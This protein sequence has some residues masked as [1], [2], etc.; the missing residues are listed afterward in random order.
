MP[1][2]GYARIAS[3]QQTQHDKSLDEQQRRINSRAMTEGWMIDE[4]IVECGVSGGQRLH[5][6]PRGSELLAKLQSGDV[7]I[8]AQLD[9]MFRSALDAVETVDEFKDRGIR[10]LVLD[11]AE[12]T[13]DN[14]I[15]ISILAAVAAFEHE[16]EQRANPP[17]PAD[18]KDRGF[19]QL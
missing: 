14:T 12:I 8:C 16:F 13:G 4:M 3:Y 19:G 2:F 1:V 7:V 5:D 18:P 15:V 17:E 11:L 6:R 10:L 9:R